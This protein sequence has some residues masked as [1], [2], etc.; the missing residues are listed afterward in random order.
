MNKRLQGK[1][2]LAKPKKTVK[3]SK[4]NNT[5]HDKEANIPSR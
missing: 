3:D 4:E 2:N 5:D 1:I